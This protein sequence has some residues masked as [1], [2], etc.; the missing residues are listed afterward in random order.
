MFPTNKRVFI[1]SRMTGLY[2][3]F[4]FK[5]IRIKI[6][7]RLTE[8][9]CDVFCYEYVSSGDSYIPDAYL[10]N[11]R[12]CDIVL[13]IID[14]ECKN[15]ITS[16]I[17]N[18]YIV[19]TRLEKQIVFC[20]RANS[21]NFKFYKHR[22]MQPNKY[23]R[24]GTNGSQEESDDHYDLR[25]QFIRDLHQKQIRLAHDLSEL[26]N[27]AVIAVKN[28]PLDKELLPGGKKIT[29]L[30]NNAYVDVPIAPLSSSQVIGSLSSLYNTKSTAVIRRTSKKTTYLRILNSIMTVNPDVDRNI[31]NLLNE[32]CNDKILEALRGNNS[33]QAKQELLSTITAR[34]NDKGIAKEVVRFIEYV[35]GGEMYG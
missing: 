30:I 34:Y 23:C 22:I 2:H 12:F 10:L 20:V 27:E 17:L 3:G 7:E 24:L 8:E 33:A 4:D 9:G 25:M 31:Y 15:P 18:E 11:I 26:V 16:A 6:K 14:E 28:C 35:L 13:F 1:S 29:E 19:A 21:H 5:K 32:C